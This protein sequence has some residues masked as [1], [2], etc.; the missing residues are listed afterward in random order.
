MFYIVA[1]PLTCLAGV[2]HCDDLI[3][4]FQLPLLFP[5]LPLGHPDLQISEILIQLW[6]DFAK[7]G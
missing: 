3:Y 5:D 4:L 7:Y 2:C 1:L 6:T